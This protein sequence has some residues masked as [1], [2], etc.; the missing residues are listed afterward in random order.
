[1]CQVRPQN[2]EEML[3]ISGVGDYKLEK[4]GERFIK[5]IKEYENSD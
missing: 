3:S 5:A 4:Y 1:M 2:D